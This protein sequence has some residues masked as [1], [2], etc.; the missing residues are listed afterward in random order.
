MSADE[1][2][3]T[4]GQEVAVVT[5]GGG[6]IGAAIAGELVAAGIHVAIFDLNAERLRNVAGGIAERG[7]STSPHQVDVSDTSSFIAAVDAVRSIH[8]RIDYLVNN[9]GING[10]YEVLQRVSEDE[11][12]AV[13]A[14][15]LK[16]VWIGMKAVLPYMREARRGAI[17]NVASTAGLTGYA[18]KSSYTAA[19]HGVIG[20]T[21]VAAIENRDIPIRVNAVCPGAVDTEMV[22]R[23]LE[24]RNASDAQ[25]AYAARAQSQPLGRFGDAAEIAAVVAFLL[26]ARASFVTGSVVAVDG[27][28][29]AGLS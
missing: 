22:R 21:R 5:G 23:P 28:L 12:D 7:G 3:A 20:L 16:S 1:R 26:S 25:N 15:T 2:A 4:L 29:L 27:G 8:G 24:E 10:G 13:M 9:A 17:V 11:F 14:A 6:G 18:N 19:K